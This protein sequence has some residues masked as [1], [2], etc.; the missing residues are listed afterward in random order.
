MNKTF[1]I[2][3]QVLKTP[4]QAYAELIGGSKENQ[5]VKIPL[6]LI[7]EVSEQPQKIHEDKI[8]RIAESMK[9]VG[10]IDPAIVIPNPNKPG[11]YILLAGRHR[12]RA[13]RL[14][15]QQEIKAVI[16]QET[17]PDKQRL[18]LLATNNDRN[19]DYSPSELAFSYLEQK[20]LLEKLGSKSTA[21]QIA[22]DNNTNRKTV[23]KYIQLT[24]LIKPLLYKVDKEEITIGAGYELSFLSTEEQNRVFVFLTNNPNSH[25][26]KQQA[27]IIRD[28]PNNFEY[29]LFDDSSSKA[30]KAEKK[31]NNNSALKNKCPSEGHNASISDETLMTTAFILYRESYSIY[32]HIV[33][34]FSTPEENINFILERYANNGTVYCD[35]LNDNDIPFDNYKNSKYSIEF[36]SNKLSVVFSSKAHGKRK[37]KIHYKDVDAIIRKYLRK[38]INKDD[39]I[40]ML[41]E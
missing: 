23:H 10:Q 17:N 28:N 40:L 5:I 34:Q 18:I 13:C 24:K 20:N 19:T 31:T 32:K 39:I 1:E 14:N 8:T 26:S 6:N 38:Y 35:F 15:G 41:R 33:Q 3:P 12:S 25:I 7:D 22:E 27:R 2:K 16:Y 30:P 4:E 36:T 11:R 21:S 9:I 29:I 37:F